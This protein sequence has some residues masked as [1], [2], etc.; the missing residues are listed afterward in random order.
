[1]DIKL[2]NSL[3]D[4]FKKS[5]VKSESNKEKKT[6]QPKD[7]IMVSSSKGLSQFI[8]KI[9]H[10]FINLMSK[11][12]VEQEDI[13]GLDIT[14]KSVRVAQLNNVKNQWILEKLAYKFVEIP[15]NTPDNRKAEIYI[16]Q[17][18]DALAAGKISTVNAAV[19]LPVS[20]AIIKVVQAPLMTDDEIDRAIEHESLW[21]NLVQLQEELDSYSIFYQVISRNSKTNTMDI[22]F[23]ASK[24]ADVKSQVNLVKQAGLNPIIVD[25]RCFSLRNA[26]D[27]IRNQKEIQLNKPV[28]LLELGSEENYLLIMRSETPHITDVFINTQDKQNL[29]SKKEQNVQVIVDRYSMQVKQAFAAYE[30]KYKTDP[31]KELYI[32]SSIQSIEN[33]VIALQKKLGKLS[34]QIFNPLSKITIPENLKKKVQAEI[35]PSVFTTV[36]GLATRKL[37]VFGY[38]KFVTGVKN[39][40]L[41]PNREVIRKSKRTEIISK[42]VFIGISALALFFIVTF[43]YTF[44]GEMKKAKKELINYSTLEQ[45]V[46]INKTK[47][48]KI[49][50]KI[51]N[52]E[53]K[54]KIGES[55]NSNQKLS[56]QVLNHINKS[57]PKGIILRSLNYDGDKKLVIK[58]LA[59]AD[60]NILDFISNLKE[61][62]IIKNAIVISMT[63]TIQDEKNP[64]N[65]KNFVI[66]TTINAQKP[67]IDKGT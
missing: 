63:K 28:A 27:L 43:T 24:V 20:S 65:L 7:K 33:F 64:S 46:N 60:K 1:M 2:F 13:V 52:I 50:S 35:N 45:N 34:I 62:N 15:S 53:S 49:N 57:Y 6:W 10:P 19:S 59:K 17:I 37:D 3:K 39:I 48:T 14:P 4:V 9:T 31:V 32:V 56:Y 42:L 5:S 67:N 16:E 61:G 66:D 26:L 25:V 8:N 47:L 51:R 29:D 55:I 30:S 22:L 44:F 11:Y 54:V 58:G 18:K 12:S 38:Y 23:V 40:N 21:Q 36:I 41:L